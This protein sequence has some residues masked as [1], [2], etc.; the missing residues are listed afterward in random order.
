MRR[1]LHRLDQ[2]LAS[3]TPFEAAKLFGSDDNNLV[4]PVHGDMLRSFAA[5]FANQFAE[6]SLGVLQ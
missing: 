4:A 3:D 6:T 1:G 5:D 2:R